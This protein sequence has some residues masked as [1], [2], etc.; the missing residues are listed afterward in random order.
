MNDLDT[1]RKFYENNIYGIWRD[2][3]TVSYCINEKTKRVS[4]VDPANP[5][6]AMFGLPTT[7]EGTDVE[8]NVEKSGKSVSFTV[9]AYLPP[10]A[11]SRDNGCPFIICMHPVAPKD[12]SLAEGVAMIFMDTSMIAEDNNL[13]KGCFYE[14]YPYEKEPE[15]QTG[16]LMAWG[17]GAAK[18]LDAIYAGLGKELGLDADRSAVT[19]VS[20]WGKAT[21]VCGAFE[22]R[23]R[24]VIPVCSG[25]GGLALWNYMSEGKTY[26][27]T[28]CGGPAE[29]TY[30]QNEP[31]S[32]L[33]SEA[34]RGWFTDKFLEYEKYSDIPVEQYMLPVLA[35]DIDRQYIIVAAWTGEDWVNAPSMWECYLKA[36]EKYEEQGLANNISAFF[37]REGHALL[38]EDLEKIIPIMKLKKY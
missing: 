38:K 34:E 1:T 25:A 37:H 27:L 6:A 17:W 26:D 15:T 19:G 32:C 30:S 10:K 2:G 20:R 28:H 5:M 23:F 9:R 8:I 33:Q 35:A 24:T 12:Y 7:D 21:A 22:K 11:V 36:K 13:R 3:E 18:V 29:Y 31:L 16:V 14:L 4:K